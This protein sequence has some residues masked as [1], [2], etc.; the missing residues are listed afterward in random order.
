MFQKLL[1]LATLS[2]TAFTASAQWTL[3]GKKVGDREFTEK[4]SGVYELSVGAD[5]IYGRFL[6]KNGDDI[7]YGAENTYV[8]GSVPY[9]YTTEGDSL[10][11]GSPVVN[12]VF[13]LDTSAGTLTVT[14]DVQPLTLRGNAKGA[15][16]NPFVM[17]PLDYQGNGIYTCKNLQMIA[18][19]FT[20]CMLTA[21]K[22][23]DFD[24]AASSLYPYRFSG[25]TV[26]A[27]N[28]LKWGVPEKIYI[29]PRGSSVNLY[30]PVQ[31]ARVDLTVNLIDVTITATGGYN[32]PQST[33]YLIGGNVAHES[34]EIAWSDSGCAKGISMTRTEVGDTVSYTIDD[35]KIRTSVPDADTDSPQ[36]QIEIAS[37]LGS[38]QEIQD[39]YCFG[40]ERQTRL[41]T[42]NANNT[43][44]TGVRDAGDLATPL[45]LPTGTYNI[46]LAFTP[47]AQPTLTAV[48]TS[49]SALESVIADEV[50][51]NA[52][53]EWFD[54]EGRKIAEPTASGVYIRHKGSVSQKVWIFVGQ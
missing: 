9:S 52:P 32:P 5:T 18:R 29:A 23:M 48:Q 45:Q 34:E 38:W 27:T 17:L 13:T 21:P 44:S 36:G 41:L 10:M 1:I 19:D 39:G 12:A 54:L 15:Y 33:L 22:T 16:W 49:T 24:A 30:F 7:L 46:A 40:W 26:T 6:L 37:N 35:V 14:G 11:L 51:S 31:T 50:D 4:S 43:C 28:T 20:I 47:T 42:L 25:A 8:C 3:S 53:T 2:T